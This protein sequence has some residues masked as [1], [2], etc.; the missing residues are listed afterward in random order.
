LCDAKYVEYQWNHAGD[1]QCERKYHIPYHRR[2]RGRPIAMAFC[3]GDSR[4]RGA[5][6]VATNEK[7][8]ET[9][10]SLIRGGGIACVVVRRWSK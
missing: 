8:S 10:L 2:N 3:I 1:I 6:L 4:L 9:Y 5:A 7:N